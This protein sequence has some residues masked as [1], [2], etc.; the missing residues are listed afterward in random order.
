MDFGEILSK[1]WKITWKFKV[2][3]IFGILAG[4]ESGRGSNF[5]YQTSSRDYGSTPTLPPGAESAFQQFLH[6]FTNPAIIVAFISIICVIVIISIV[7][8]TIGKIGLIKG[9]SMA[10]AGAE[11]LTFGEL[12]NGSLPYFWRMF[13]MWLLT[14]LPFYIVTVLL[15]LGFIVALLPASRSGSSAGN[16]AFLVLL[17][18]LCVFFCVIML[19]ALVVSFVRVQAENA[20][21]VENEGVVSGLKRGWDVLVK[22][23]GPIFVVWL[24]MLA[25]G[26][27]AGVVIALPLLV[28]LVPLMLSFI[29]TNQT[30][31][32]A[33]LIM[34]GLCFVAYLPVAWLLNGILLTYSQS[35]W[36]LTYLRLTK[37]KQSEENSPIALPN[38]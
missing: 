6:W 33:P 27:V 17:P 20:I 30:I 32:F 22:N 24:I 36:T 14:G 7:L 26:I 13:G 5:N 10:D 35:V 3:W 2:L 28:I 19:L 37:P 38:A 9:A 15:V 11:K 4:C 34:A 12:W 16:S 18:I 1:A 25:I 8:G 23:F 31:S 29:N 21:V